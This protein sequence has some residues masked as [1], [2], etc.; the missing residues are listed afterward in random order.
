MDFITF[1]RIIQVTYNKGVVVVEKDLYEEEI[2]FN[3]F[4]YNV[5]LS[6]HRETK[7]QKRRSK[8]SFKKKV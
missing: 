2:A 7:A 1:T 5:F 6:L 8:N 3:C 4:N